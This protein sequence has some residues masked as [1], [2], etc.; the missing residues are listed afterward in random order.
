MKPL[1]HLFKLRWILAE[2]AALLLITGSVYANTC[3]TGQVCTATFGGQVYT[4][5]G[6]CDLS[7]SATISGCLV[8]GIAPVTFTPAPGSCTLSLTL[9]QATLIVQ[10]PYETATQNLEQEAKAQIASLRNIPNDTLNDFWS[11]G[12]ILAYMYL[13]ILGMANSTTALTTSDQAVANYYTNLI[14]TQRANI[15]NEAIT[16]YNQWNANPC[17]FQVPVGNPNAYLNGAA[18]ALCAQIQNDPNICILSGVCTPDPPTSAQ[19]TEWA[20]GVILQGN[21]QGWGQLLYSESGILFPA[22]PTTN[23]PMTSLQVAQTIAQVEYDQAY[24]GVAEGVEYLTAKHASITNVSSSTET[25]VESDLQQAWIDGLHDVGGDQFREVI[26]NAVAAVFKGGTAGGESSLAENLGVVGQADLKLG[27]ALEEL[28]LSSEDTEFPNTTVNLAEDAAAETA[29]EDLVSEGGELVGET[30]DSVVGPAIAGAVVI[31]FETWQTI[32]NAEV[33][34]QLQASLCSATGGQQASSACSST[35]PESLNTYAQDPNGRLTILTA[36][37]ESALPDFSTERLSSSFGFAPDAGPVAP[38][39]PSFLEGTAAT[40][41]GSFSSQDWDGTQDATSVANGWFVQSATNNNGA[42]QLAYLSSVSYLTPSQQCATP[43]NGGACTS[44]NQEGWRAWLDGN[45]LLAQREFVQAGVGNVQDATNTCPS[46]LLPQGN[47]DLGD[48]CVTGNFTFTIQQGDEVS[49]EGQVRQVNG[50]TNTNGNITAFQTSEPFALDNSG[51][52]PSGPILVLTNADGN[53]LSSSTLGSRVTGPDCTEGTTISTSEGIVTIVPPATVKF[54]LAAL[55]QKTYGNPPFNV[56]SYATSNSTGALT[57]SVASGSNGCTVDA[58]GNVTITGAG[59]CILNVAQAAA[60]TF[61]AST[62]NQAS[63][64][65]APAPL[66]VTASSPSMTYGGTVPT[67]TPSYMGF[68]N[69]DTAANLVSQPICQTT[70][71][72][73]SAVGSYQ[74]ACVPPTGGTITCTGPIGGPLTCTGALDSL[75][76]NYAATFYAGSLTVTQAPLMITASSNTVVLGGPIPAI[77]PS[78]S[79]FVNS[80]NASSLTTQ[81]TCTTTVTSSSAAGTYTGA[82]TCSGAV[83]PNYAFTYVAG[84]MKVTYNVPA[85]FNQTSPVNSNAA[86]PIK[87]QISNYSGKNISSPA[88]TL[89]IVGFTPNPAPGVAPSGTFTY[90]VGDSG[91]MYQ[92]NV[93]T[94]DYPAGTYTLSFTV[95]GDPNVH[96]VSFVVVNK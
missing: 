17:G 15:A 38:T 31:A 10:D 19:F 96:S 66:A 39:D 33:L 65:I 95:T 9:C 64:V 69:G 8:V 89:T 6:P 48:V 76:P 1:S 16:L 82:D 81:P 58:S 88:I 14:N 75:S 74:T 60:S 94:K 5:L 2:L 35:S 36:L 80:Q 25:T 43:S 53:C 72:S 84:T 56:A 57:F 44:I 42:S 45:Q 13:R 41:T 23:P 70:A 7:S 62:E 18:G 20:T 51:N 77:M 12:E 49:I 47:T 78:Y 71:T 91:P 22:T 29:E 40:P 24:G 3:A 50:V 55:T 86:V 59:T 83:D 37:V 87:I 85:L 73:A 92:F 34:P 27:N 11:R 68:V 21:V 61:G 63:F 46:T 54:S 32:L 67:I 93:K 26:I 52:L 4:V 30:W 28:G 90:T 79:G